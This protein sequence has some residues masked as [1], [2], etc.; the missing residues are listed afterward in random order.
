MDGFRFD[1]APALTRDPLRRVRPL[2]A[3]STP[4][5]QDPVLSRVKL[6][7]EAWD[8]GVRRLPGWRLS[9][10]V[11]ATGTTSF[12]DGGPGHSGAATHGN[13]PSLAQ[14]AYRGP[15]DTFNHSGRKPW[16]S[17]QYVG[18]A[19]WLHPAGRRQSYDSSPQPAQRREQQGRARAQ[20]FLQQRR[21]GTDHAT[22]PSWLSRNRQKRNL[23]ATTILSIGT[24]MLLM[25]DEFSRS[26]ERQQQRLLPRQ[27][28]S[29]WLELDATARDPE[30]R[31][32]RRQP[33]S[34]LRKRHRG[35][36]PTR[37]LRPA[38]IIEATGLKDVYWLTSRRSERWPATT[39][40]RRRAPRA[41]ACR[42]ATMATH[43]ERILLALQRV[44]TSRSW[45][46][47][48]RQLRSLARAFRPFFRVDP[49]RRGLCD[50][51]RE[52][53]YGA[54]EAFPLPSRSFVLLQHTSRREIFRT[55]ARALHADALR[56]RDRPATV[57][58][59]PSGRRPPTRRGAG[60]RR[61]SGR[62]AGDRPGLV[63][64]AST[65][66]PSPV[67][68]TGYAIDGAADLVPDPASR[69]QQEDDDRRSTDRRSRPPTSG[70]DNGWDGRPWNEVVLYETHVGTATPSR[71]LR[72]RSAAKLDRR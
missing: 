12:R 25:G 19:R 36:P 40:G 33:R 64:A 28:R 10:P 54:G 44:A 48:A 42:S 38:R 14:L 8:L 65:R 6:I 70:A 5:R 49:S 3:S 37:V 72:R 7:A 45:T 71:H 47:A 4:S 24:P 58:A 21:R 62:H 26:P 22:P 39:W 68:A 67:S 43:R 15:S 11:G 59:S 51:A 17:V 31:R 9:R 13:I 61:A 57:C 41:W 35:V 66:R 2:R 60:L 23:L 16:A 55:D 52:M 20:L 34:A 27:P 18:L 30:P 32:L 1:L 46:S 29:N 69:F 56:G 63:Q 53:L 50:T